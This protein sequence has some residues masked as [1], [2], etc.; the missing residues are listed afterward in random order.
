MYNEY[1]NSM[2]TLNHIVDVCYIPSFQLRI[3]YNNEANLSSSMNISVVGGRGVVLVFLNNH[4]RHEVGED[5]QE[6]STHPAHS[7]HDSTVPH[8]HDGVHSQRVIHRY[9]PVKAEEINKSKLR[10]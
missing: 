9:K 8:C 7:H 4:V 10:A 6:Q 2:A 3:L 1:I 5:S